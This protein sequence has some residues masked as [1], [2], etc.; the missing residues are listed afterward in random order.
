MES[1]SIGQVILV[2]FPFSDLSSKK[3]RPCLIVGLAEFND[4]IVCQLTSRSYSS[5]RA[6]PLTVNDFAS[7]SLIIDSYVRP[8]KIATLDKT[9]IKQVI[10]TIKQKKLAEI[11]NTLC[12]IFELA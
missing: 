8:D 11:K 2:S 3:I 1:I 10:G 7:G 9:V 5:K 6:I 12:V 4:I